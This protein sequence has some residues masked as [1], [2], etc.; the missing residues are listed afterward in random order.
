MKK[1]LLTVLCGLLA[2]SAFAQSSKGTG[3]ISGVVIDSI[4]K[5][6]ID[7]ATIALMRIADA[8]SINGGLSDDKGVFKLTGIPNGDYKLVVTFIGYKTTATKK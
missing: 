2:A 1:V 8:K 6:P 5:Q 7:F 3:K 4:S